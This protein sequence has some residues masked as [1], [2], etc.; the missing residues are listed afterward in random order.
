MPA[1]LVESIVMPCK[2]DLSKEHTNQVKLMSLLQTVRSTNNDISD[3][4]IKSNETQDFS[5]RTLRL[6]KN[7]E[8]QTLGLKIK[9]KTDIFALYS[10]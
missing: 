6:R 5:Q 2:P 8:S 10:I 7:H 9:W 1:E 4:P 3:Q